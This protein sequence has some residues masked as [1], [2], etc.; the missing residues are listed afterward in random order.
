VDP[1]LHVI[2]AAVVSL[3]LLT[4]VLVKP[5]ILRRRPVASIFAAGGVIA[6]LVANSAS[7]DSF[8]VGAACVLPVLIGLLLQEMRD[9]VAAA[10]DSR[11]ARNRRRRHRERSA[12]E[13]ERA[14]QERDERR[15]A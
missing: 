1:S 5:G 3:V 9:G 8:L 4:L 6:A 13:R 15:A 14:R 2:L 7:D 10:A 12:S 11:R